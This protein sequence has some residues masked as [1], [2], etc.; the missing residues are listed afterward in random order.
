MKV[1]TILYSSERRVSGYRY[2]FYGMEMDDL[3]T[4]V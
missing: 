1:P 4:M 2:G 3:R